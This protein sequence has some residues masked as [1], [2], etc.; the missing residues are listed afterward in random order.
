MYDEYERSYT[1]RSRPGLSLG[2]WILLGLAGLVLTGTAISVAGFFFV[3]ERVRDV[4]EVQ[5]VVARSV[6]PAVEVANLLSEL[7]P[8]LEAVDLAGTSDAALRDTRS[9]A[10]AGFNLQE[11]TEGR[12]QLRDRDLSRLRLDVRGGDRAGSLVLD[13]DGERVAVDFERD[14]D[15]GAVVIRSSEGTI[16]LGAGGRAADLPAWVPS[17]ADRPD[18]PVQIYSARTDEATVGAVSWETDLTPEQVVDRFDDALG[19]EG[20]SADRRSVR[21]HPGESRASLTFRE[22]DGE[23]KAFVV[24][25]DDGGR[26]RVILGYRSDR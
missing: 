6:L 18:R 9:G 3:R 19:Y 20:L 23:R 15:G 4:V 13:A 7:D 11:L 24:A 26:T 8:A 14:A 12:L 1:G 21:R 22:L 10:V 25:V 5:R 2:S 16:T 17:V